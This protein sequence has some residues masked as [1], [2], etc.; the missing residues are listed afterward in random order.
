MKKEKN[1]LVGFALQTGAASPC[2]GVVLILQ[3]NSRRIY[4]K[5]LQLPKSLS[6]RRHRWKSQEKHKG[7]PRFTKPL[8]F[9]RYFRIFEMFLGRFNSPEKIFTGITKKKRIF[10]ANTPLTHTQKLWHTLVCSFFLLWSVSE[11][12]RHHFGN[13][14]RDFRFFRNFHWC[15]FQQIFLFFH[16]TLSQNCATTNPR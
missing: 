12:L 16:Q 4:R 2:K 3:T 10:V 8:Y 6:R 15:F 5:S 7:L 13:I 11:S 1:R 9:P 14:A